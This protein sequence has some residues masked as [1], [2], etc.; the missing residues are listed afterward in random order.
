MIRSKRLLLILLTLCFLLAGCKTGNSNISSSSVEKP[1]LPG[2]LDLNSEGIPI[3]NVYDIADEKTKEMDIESYIEGV[4]AGEMKND[5]PIEALKAQAI[6]A[7]T[8][9][10]KFCDTKDSRYENADISTDIEEAQAYAP[11]NINNRIRQAV[12][13][14]RGMI[15]TTGN[16]YPHAWFHAHSGGYTE[17]PSAALDFKKEDPEYLSVVKSMDSEDAPAAVKNWTASFTDEEILAACRKLNLDIGDIEE[18]QIGKKSASGRA[19]TLRINGE[20]VSAPSFRIAIGANKL[21][22]T[23]ISELSREGNITIFSGHGFGHGVGMSQWGAYALAEQGKSAQDIVKY[24][25]KD[26]SITQMW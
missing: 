20:E 14:T 26:I 24:Y 16:D 25:F 1:V 22:S 2:K 18:I 21:K 9:V 10:L 5:W 7:R 4:I 6:L 12:Q 17:L 15:M 19:V 3:L 13:E 8:F 11:E 23:L